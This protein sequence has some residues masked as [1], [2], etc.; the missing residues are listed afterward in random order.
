MEK[1]SKGNETNLGGGSETSANTDEK[2]MC[3]D[4]VRNMECMIND[5]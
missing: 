1:L 5:I 4:S 3:V 2:S